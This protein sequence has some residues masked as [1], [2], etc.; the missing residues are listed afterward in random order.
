MRRNK[1]RPKDGQME[2]MVPGKTATSWGLGAG[3]IL[4]A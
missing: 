3:T 2:E 4:S 1:Q